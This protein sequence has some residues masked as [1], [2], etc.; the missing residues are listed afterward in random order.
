MT[1]IFWMNITWSFHLLPHLA[2]CYFFQV[3][4]IF[5]LFLFFFLLKKTVTFLHHLLFIIPP[6][7]RTCQGLYHL[8]SSIMLFSGA[9]PTQALRM[10]SSMALCLASA[11]T[12]GVPGGT[13]SFINQTPHQF[14][15]I[16]QHIALQQKLTEICFVPASENGRACSLVV[17]INLTKITKFWYILM[18]SNFGS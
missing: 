9:S 2:S 11:F 12:T 8:Y 14:Q 15:M 3:F 17:K 10:F 5:L 4:L 13:C 18:L 16:S 1:P 7:K 6:D